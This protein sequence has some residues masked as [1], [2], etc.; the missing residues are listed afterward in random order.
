MGKFSEVNVPEGPERFI[1]QVFAAK[2]RNTETSS[3]RFFKKKMFLAFIDPHA[4]Q[5][6]KNKNKKD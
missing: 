4:P 5:K 3:L 6:N 2:Q 1:P